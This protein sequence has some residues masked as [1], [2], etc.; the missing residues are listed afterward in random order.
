MATNAGCD[1]SGVRPK[2]YNDKLPGFGWKAHVRVGWMR[3]VVNK[4]HMDKS[5]TI[6]MYYSEVQY[7]LAIICVD[8]DLVT[9]LDIVLGVSL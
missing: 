2:T 9:G 5:Q 4:M 7:A 6:L 1:M 3:C 8:A